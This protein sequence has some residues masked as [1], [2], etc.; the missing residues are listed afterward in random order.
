MHNV[1]ENIKS[2]ICNN[3]YYHLN[4]L[5]QLVFNNPSLIC[6]E[7]LFTVTPPAF[8]SWKIQSVSIHSKYLKWFTCQTEVCVEIWFTSICNAIVTWTW[9]PKLQFKYFSNQYHSIVFKKSISL[10]MKLTKYQR[11]RIMSYYVL[12][13]TH[14]AICSKRVITLVAYSVPVHHTGSGYFS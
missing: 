4:S 9:L 7:N 11:L 13:F 8:I 2:C 3:I 6:Y 5:D 1:I 14:L 10:V 12:I